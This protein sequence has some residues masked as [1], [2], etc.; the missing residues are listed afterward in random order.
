MNW[1]SGKDAAMALHTLQQSPHLRCVS[2]LTSISQEFQRVSMHG[3]RREV[4]EAQAKAIDLPLAL[5]ELPPNASMEIYD[6]VFQQTLKR[7]KGRQ[8]LTAAYGD[9]FLE[10]LRVY[11]EKQC[12]PLGME[13]LF[14]L[15]KRNT[16]DL[17][18]SFVDLGFEAIV[19]CLNENKLPPEF[20][21]RTIDLD[22]I[23]DLPK[24]VDPCGENGEFHTF[25][26]KGPIFNAPVEFQLGEK[27]RRS[28]TDPQEETKEIG[29]WF[30]DIL[31]PQDSTEV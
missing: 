21:G 29:Y 27:I 14:P 25:C 1:S 11:R 13:L 15:W 8:C 24:D 23:R 19:V 26:Y 20:L 9:I 28:Y 5:M 12:Q 6:Q 18:H 16:R 31:L 10:D 4:L 2:L 7:F 3:L 22:F 17:I 30:L